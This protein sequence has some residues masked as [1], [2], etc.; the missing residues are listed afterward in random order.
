MAKIDFNAIQDSA[1]PVASSNRVSFFGL[2]NDKD[3][4]IVRIMH[5][6]SDSFDLVTVHAVQLDNR[7]RKVNCI[8]EANDPIDACPFCAAGVALQQRIYIHMLVYARDDSGKIIAQPMV[9]ERPASYAR[10]LLKL[11]ND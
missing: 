7:F 1:Q 6:S 5:D 8:R 11:K 10:T 4:A 3:T 2:K 9:W